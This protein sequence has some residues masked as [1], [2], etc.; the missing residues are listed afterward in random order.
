MAS[1][2]SDSL[3]VSWGGNNP[4]RILKTTKGVTIEFLLDVGTHMEAQNKKN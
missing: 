3:M 2:F 4:P 1:A